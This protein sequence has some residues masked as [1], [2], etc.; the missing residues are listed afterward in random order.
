MRGRSSRATTITAVLLCVGAV[1][2]HVAPAR[3]QEG[4]QTGLRDA[5]RPG[6][7]MVRRAEQWGR[8][9]SAA[10]RSAEEGALTGRLEEELSAWKQRCRELQLANT[11]LQEQLAAGEQERSLRWPVSP[12]DPLVVPELVSASVLGEEAAT[13][14]RGGALIDFGSQPGLAESTL[15]LEDSRPLIDQGRDAGMEAGQAVYRGRAVVGRIAK[16]GR[17]VSTLQHVTDS[18]YRGFAQVA[19]PTTAGLAWGPRGILVGCG[20]A[21]CRLTE[22]SSTESVDAGD[23]VYAADTSFPEP[24]YYGRVV[25]AELEAG[26]LRWRVLVEPAV[27]RDGLRM[28]QVLRRTVNPAR[29]RAH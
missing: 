27:P 25:E 17:W 26:G 4:I 14:L 5:L 7:V 24:M 20:E 22:I 23:E 12:R 29:L 19:R 8:G 28:V 16:V 18:E 3:V 9:W 15:V 2:L 1:A 11:R 21:L 6:Q 13:L 10:N